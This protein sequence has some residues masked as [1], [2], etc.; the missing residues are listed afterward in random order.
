LVGALDLA[1][2]LEPLLALKQRAR[3]P[4]ISA[5]LHRKGEAATLFPPFVV[6]EKMGKKVLVVGVTNPSGQ[7]PAALHAAG[8]EITDPKAALLSQREAIAAQKP[9]LVIL[10]SNLGMDATIALGAEQDV[11]ALPVH[12]ALVSGS[13]RQ[14]YQP[15]FSQSVPVLEADQRGK[16][17]G[18]LDVHIVDHEVAFAPEE[19]KGLAQVR[20]YMDSY[21]SVFNA[22]RSVFQVRDAPEADPRAQQIR[23]NLPLAL[24]RLAQVERA[25]PGSVQLHQAPASKSW[26]LT[27]MIPVELDL[28]QDPKVRKLLDGYIKKTAPLLPAPPKPPKK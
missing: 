11:R 18:R 20:E 4:W 23:R 25:L 14:T 10:L 2:G 24:E 1:M 8:L 6:T 19:P 21:R 26:L 3:F 5:N 9:D 16:F 28:A 15:V 13:S 12:V 22:R 27:Q 17:L 7:D